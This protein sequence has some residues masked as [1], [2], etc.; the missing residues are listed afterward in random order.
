MIR[1]AYQNTTEYIDNIIVC[2]NFLTE[3]EIKIGTEIIKNGQWKYGHY[4]LGKNL[5]EDDFWSMDLI[6]NEFFSKKILEIIEKHFS[7]KF[8][9]HR[10]YANA[11]TFGQDGHFHTDSEI[12]G[13]YTF[14]L[15]FS[16]INEEYVEPA[17][18]YL[19]FKIPNE[20]YKIGFEP[21]F[22]RGIFF[23][24]AYIHKG[25]SYTRYVMDMRICVAW[26]LKLINE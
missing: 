7:K 20:K 5:Y 6:D 22:N 11:H 26:K 18:G 10:V 1:S 9:L 21:L 12:D 23:P 24:S 19:Y 16:K 17:G 4:S 14:C 13:N 15:Y 25:T 3:E 8:E 2:D